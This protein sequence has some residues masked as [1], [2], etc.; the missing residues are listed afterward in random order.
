[1][2]RRRW[3][4]SQ[5]P[6]LWFVLEL[7]PDKRTDPLMYHSTKGLV[8]SLQAL[9]RT[10]ENFCLWV[11]FRFRPGTQTAYY[12]NV[13]L[14]VFWGGNPATSSAKLVSLLRST[15]SPCLYNINCQGEIIFQ[16]PQQFVPKKKEWGPRA[17]GKMITRVYGPNYFTHHWTHIFIER[18]L[19]F[20][21]KM[22]SGNVKIAEWANIDFTPTSDGQKYL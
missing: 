10:N 5:K 11:R 1:M 19:W 18:E 16:A 21:D 14:D 3:K 7:M 13:L 6:K 4:R 9:S 12:Y 20:I 8:C 15:S 17:F 2:P 22:K